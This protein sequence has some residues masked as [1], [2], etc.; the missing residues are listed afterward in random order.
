MRK[1]IALITADMHLRDTTPKCRTD[2]YFL[3]Q[4]NKL[5]F[6]LGKQ[7]ELNIPILDAGDLLNG[8]RCSPFLEA[9]L[10]DN[11]PKHI[12]TIPGNHDL[13]Y[14]NLNCYDKSSLNVLE[15]ASSLLVLK[16]ETLNA[17]KFYL[18]GKAFSFNED[19][20]YELPDPAKNKLK[21]AMM[22]TFVSAK[23]EIPNT[24]S[25]ESLCKKFKDFDIIITGH[26][27]QS[28][29]Y[30]S[31]YNKLINPGS[32]MRMFADQIDFKPRLF[33][34]FDDGSI[35]FEYFPIQ[36][37]VI[38]R[39]HLEIKEER[40][41]RLESFLKNMNKSYKKKFDFKSNISSFVKENKTEQTVVNKIMEALQ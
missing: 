5:K 3:A 38:D 40:D 30:E 1:P 22:H 8:Y 32:M 10:I 20:N 4:E 6:L 12:I 2:N 19:F 17:D 21:I 23:G 15:K 9:Y 11:L 37:D 25:A 41:K 28:F 7:R 26:N 27:H 24:H 35:D 29:V 13:P 31:D 14:N 18:C 33:I 34:L 16:N 39:K 36:E